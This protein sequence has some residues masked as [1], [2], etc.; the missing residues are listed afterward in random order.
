MASKD[1]DT[2]PGNLRPGTPRQLFAI[3]VLTV[4]GVGFMVLGGLFLAYDIPRHRAVGV[5]GSIAVVAFGGF[6]VSMAIVGVV[7]WFRYKA[8]RYGSEYD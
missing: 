6:L 8:G 4:G 7:I 5:V 1:K 2:W 3:A